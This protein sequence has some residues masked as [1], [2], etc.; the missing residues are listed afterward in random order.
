MSVQARAVT[1]CHK[2]LRTCAWTLPTRRHATNTHVDEYFMAVG[3][4]LLGAK[5][6]SHYREGT[7]RRTYIRDLA[8]VQQGKM[9]Y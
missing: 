7:A 9:D 4:L 2:P 8:S 5:M 3:W 1:I 6:D